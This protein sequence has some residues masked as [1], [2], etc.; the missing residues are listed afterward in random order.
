MKARM[1]VLAA[2]LPC[3]FLPA[4]SADEIRVD[5]DKRTIYVP[6]KVA[7]RKIE[8]KA[9][10]GMIYPVEGIATWPF[11]KGK[12]AHETVVT[13]DVKPSEVHKA[14]EELGL[15]PGKPAK[16][17]KDVQTGP[18]VKLF[19]EI[20]KRR[21]PVQN[22]LKDT[23]TGLA[24]PK[25]RWLFTGSTMMRPDPKKPEVYGAD[26]T[27]TLITVFPVTADTVF[28]S[29]M[30]LKDEKLVKLEVNDKLPKVG[31]PVTLVIVAPQ[32]K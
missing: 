2:V 8:D 21:S 26:A 4:S 28:Q 15:K 19:L 30:S 20:N 11:P 12:K 5:K 27:G 6:A 3:L 7:P 31:T 9:F 1:S 32:S 17:E 18:E 23:K 16:T 14:L 10:Q 13:F 29:D 25:V 22:F 24:M